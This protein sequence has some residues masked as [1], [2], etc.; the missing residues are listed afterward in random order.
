MKTSYLAATSH[1]A[2]YLEPSTNAQYY[3]P[4]QMVI[5]D[6]YTKQNKQTQLPTT[7]EINET[8]NEN[9]WV[10]LFIKWHKVHTKNYAKYR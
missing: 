9:Y 10:M 5:Y 8:S 1:V 4:L 2:N 6:E 3:P 7:A